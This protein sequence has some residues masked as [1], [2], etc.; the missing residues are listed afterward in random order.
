MEDGSSHAASMAGILGE[1]R[2]VRT[3]QTPGCGLLTHAIIKFAD[4][5]DGRSSAEEK[6]F[7]NGR[8]RNGPQ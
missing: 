2:V 7:L 1:T 4:K 5:L 6:N 3:G 8:Q